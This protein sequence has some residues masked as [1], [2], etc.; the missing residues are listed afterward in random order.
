MIQPAIE[1]QTQAPKLV[2]A[3]PWYALTGSSKILL[4]IIIGGL[5]YLR[6]W[7]RKRQ[8]DHVCDHCGHRNP[9]HRANC[10]RCSA[11]LFGSAGK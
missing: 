4:L 7:K 6:L 10:T 5:L 1:L 2:A 9:P 3:R 8:R 11:P